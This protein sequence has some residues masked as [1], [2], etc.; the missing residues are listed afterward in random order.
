[1]SICRVVSC[2]VGRGWQLWSVCS[3]GNTLLAFVLL[4]FVLQGQTYLYS[5]YLFVLY[6]CIPEPYDE[7]DFFVVFVLDSLAGL[8]RM[9]QLQLLWHYWLGHKLGILWYWMVCL[10]NEQKSFCCFWDWTQVLHFTFFC[11]L[12]WLHSIS[13]KEFLPTVVD[14]M[15]IW[16]KFACSN[17][18]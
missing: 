11:W 13:S 3:L 7:K 9:I 17:P 4:H 14:I 6:F 10:G 1:M 16:F 5:R 2:V 18:F 15:V 8:L 12:W